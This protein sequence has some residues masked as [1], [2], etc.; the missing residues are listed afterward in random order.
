MAPKSRAIQNKLKGLIPDLEFDADYAWAGAFGESSTS[1]PLLGAVP[2]M[3][4]AYAVMGFGGNGIT[5]SVIGS[6]VIGAAIR[7]RRDPDADL[8]AFG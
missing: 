8:F 5:Y 6:Q 1:L 4:R 3:P 7:G 2:E